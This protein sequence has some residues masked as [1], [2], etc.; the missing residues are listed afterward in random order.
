LINRCIERTEVDPGKIDMNDPFGFVVS[1]GAAPS[2]VDAAYRFARHQ[3]GVH[4]VL[5]GTGDISHLKQNIE[6]ICAEPLP[7]EILER[8]HDCFGTI[9]STIGN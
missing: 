3:Q 4:V 1:S 5:T 7:H 9:I 6:S 2:V 8:I